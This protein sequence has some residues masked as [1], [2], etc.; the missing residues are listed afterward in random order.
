M[1]KYLL[2]MF[3][4]SAFS[5]PSLMV[6]NI[7]RVIA[8]EPNDAETLKN[9]S[10]Y[11]SSI[12][13]FETRFIQINPTGDTV[14]GN[15]IYQKP[16]RL[17]FKYD[18]P[19]TLSVAVDGTTLYVQE[20]PGD[21]PDTYPVNA[22]PLPLFFSSNLDLQSSGAVVGVIR[23]Q[24]LTEI[25]LQDPDGDIPGRLYMSFN[26]PKAKLRGWRVV[27]AQGQ[28]ITLLLRDVKIIEKIDDRRFK[29]DYK[30]KSGP[31]R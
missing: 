2:F 5:L 15:L 6:P 28:I 23:T 11:F 17:L 10:A 14:S 3:L 26:A 29:L 13:A 16:S 12:P 18:A 31:K 30:R 20:K 9:I 24:G 8:A 1:K 21:R 27:D 22:T 4:V 19:N 25:L 7:G